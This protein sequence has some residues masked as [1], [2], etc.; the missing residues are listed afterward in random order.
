MLRK[1][2]IACLAL[3]TLTFAGCGDGGQQNVA[4]NEE[5]QLVLTSVQDFLQ[6][7]QARE[8]FR[9]QR[10]LHPDAML[11]S[12]DLRGDSVTMKMTSSEEWLDAMAYKGPPLIERI[13][14]PVVQYSEAL[15]SVWTAYEFRIGE[16]L[17]HCGH[18][19]FQL[20]KSDEGRWLI[21]GV[22]YTMQDCQ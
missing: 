5:T 17:S 21:A 16:E 12:I 8:K 6:A 19:A 11:T 20:V 2:L 14:N 7:L 22:T 15:A 9:L 3:S 13:E 18:D 4:D 10:V 1:I